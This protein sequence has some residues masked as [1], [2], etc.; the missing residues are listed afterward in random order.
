MRNSDS[1][2]WLS[3]TVPGSTINRETEKQI[4]TYLNIKQQ[5]AL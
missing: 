2:T 3:H 1:G 4:N 5:Q